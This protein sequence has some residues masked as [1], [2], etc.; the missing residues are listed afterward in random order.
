[1]AALA[2]ALSVPDGGFTVD[3]TTGADVTAGY[4]VSVDPYWERVHEHPVTADDLAAYLATARRA[5]ALPR[6]VLGGW[7][8]PNS[9][10]I[11]LD[12]SV[13]VPTLAEA[14]ELG[15]S[16]GQLAVFDLTARK[17]IPVAYDGG[18][19]VIPLH[20]AANRHRVPRPIRATATTAPDG[21]IWVTVDG[22]NV[23]QVAAGISAICD[24]LIAK[25][26]PAA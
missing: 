1:M 22:E 16:A 23:R 3:P 7:R 5:F 6:R 8:D 11:Y 14:L 15:R 19:K 9:G 20:T 2:G 24:A 21:A 4:A 25:R 10:R 18:A 12:V 17:S 26:P 13:V